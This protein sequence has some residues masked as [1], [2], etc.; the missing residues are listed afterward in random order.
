MD[1][2]ISDRFLIDEGSVSF[3]KKF[4]SKYSKKYRVQVL[5]AN[6]DFKVEGFTCVKFV[7]DERAL[8]LKFLK[9]FAKLFS[10]PDFVNIGV[11]VDKLCNVEG[12]PF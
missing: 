1:C 5:K 7:C 11:F 8:L 4:F 9:K 3:A 10:S 12:E 2:L 6:W